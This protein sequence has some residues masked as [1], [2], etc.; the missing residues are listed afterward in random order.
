MAVEN[1][2]GGEEWQGRGKIDGWMSRD[3]GDVE[4]REREIAKEQRITDVTFLKMLSKVD[5]FD[6]AEFVS[7][8]NTDLTL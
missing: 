1:I 3:R 8:G 5:H 7:T 4:R 6:N 2:L